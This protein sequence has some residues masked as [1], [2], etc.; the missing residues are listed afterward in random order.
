LKIFRRV[1]ISVLAYSL[2]L[3]ILIVVVTILVSNFFIREL[4]EFTINTLFTKQD[5]IVQSIARELEEGSELLSQLLR[6]YDFS[7]DK[8]Y[9]QLFKNIK[10]QLPYSKSIHIT[11]LGEDGT[12]IN[13]ISNIGIKINKPY[14]LDQSADNVRFIL[15]SN[16]IIISLGNSYLDSMNL[17]SL[18]P[19]F[20]D[21]YENMRI[22]MQLFMEIDISSILYNTK[23]NFSNDLAG[24]E[25]KDYEVSIYSADMEL[26]ETTENYPMK[27]L[28]TLLRNTERRDL[29]SE[30]E[31]IVLK[32]KYNFQRITKNNIEL[33]N[34]T[35]TGFIIKGT[36][37]YSIILSKVGYI[38]ILIVSIGLIILILLVIISIYSIRYRH[39]KE[40]EV[41]LQI[42][43]IQTKLN[44]H[45]IFNTLNSMVGLVYDKNYKKLF[46]AFKT[47][48]ALLRSSLEISKKGTLLSEEMEYIRNYIEIQR[49]RY[50]DIFDFHCE[51]LDE[52][53]LCIYIPH[54]S[55]QPIIENCFVHAIAVNEDKNK[56]I[57]IR[58]LI[59]RVGRMMY[60][61]IMNSGFCDK[62][63]KVD[64]LERLA[65]GSIDDTRG[66]M[67]LVLIN[68]EIKLL[69]GNKFGL[70]V[71]DKDR[72]DIFSIRVKLPA[73]N[74]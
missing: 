42:E 71:L 58:I 57:D 3:V 59:E 65:K 67:G 69:Y 18:V 43:T 9:S 5:I 34:L 49:L 31:Q 1:D 14:I 48:S 53:L 33:Y 30:V 46:S 74:Q 16:N 40:R 7:E 72:E 32:E 70:E 10:M 64:L 68:R 25:N 35:S 29:L 13:T 54:F 17:N 44:P 27:R 26:I 73:Y 12:V 22:R 24:I 52:S 45:F 36:Y 51:I 23:F 21:Y 6:T 62:K 4:T 63:T 56:R 55:I 60:I 19:I 41:I 20:I 50:E 66:H 15:F 47:L 38:G 8:D 39:I 2:L 28:E 61:D 11:V 37:P